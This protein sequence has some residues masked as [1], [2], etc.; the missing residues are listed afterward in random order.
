MEE[1][2]NSAPEVILPEPPPPPVANDNKR[3][4]FRLAMLLIGGATLMLLFAALMALIFLQKKETKIASSSSVPTATPTPTIEDLLEPPELYPE[5][6]WGEF[7]ESEFNKSLG[8]SALY[9]RGPIR[10]NGMEWEASKDNLNRD[11][12]NAL[13][14]GF[15][16]YYDSELTKKGWSNNYQDKQYDL[17][18]L[19]ADGPGGSI[20]GYIKVNNGK[21]RVILLEKITPVEDFGGVAK[22]PCDVGLR[23]FVSDIEPLE[24]L[25]KRLD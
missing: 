17:S 3:H 4:F 14:T 8:R 11:S 9:S 18:P 13:L 24:E 21:A 23:V 10:M 20:W 25:V 15:D 19:A 16:K 7:V 12:M 6:N 1:K 2:P 5:V 22:C